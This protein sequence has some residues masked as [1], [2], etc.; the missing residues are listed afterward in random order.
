[1]GR[2]AALPPHEKARIV[3]EVLSGRI[4]LAQAAAEA[5]VSITAVG[6]WKRAFPRA[7]AAGLAPPGTTGA[8]ELDAL[9]AESEQL[10]EQLRD[11]QVLAA[12]WRSSARTQTRQDDLR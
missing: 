8:S 2:S 12:V 10:T 11:A 7:A 5:G 4:T 3:L 9:R 1:M 6:N